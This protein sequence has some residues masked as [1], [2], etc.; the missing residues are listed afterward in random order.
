[1]VKKIARILLAALLVAPLCSNAAI[2]TYENTQLG[3]DRWRTEYSVTAEAGETVEEFTVFF[4]AANYANLSVHASPA[5]WSSIV[6]PPDH[7]LSAD[8]FFDALALAGALA[9]GASLSGFAVEYDFLAAG[10][11]GTQSFDI[12]DPISFATISSGR[13]TP[14][15]VIPPPTGV[16]APGTLVLF[17]I[18]AAALTRARARPS[19]TACHS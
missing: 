5:D 7:A 17:A 14:T 3:G 1:M 13:T 8:G 6:I 16:P 11:P 15:V 19:P 2:I 12:I 18:G 4:A 10:T 9:N